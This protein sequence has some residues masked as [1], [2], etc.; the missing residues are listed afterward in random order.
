LH[1]VLS[2]LFLG[3]AALG[4]V[5]LLFPSR[6][7]RRS[8]HQILAIT[9]PS[10]PEPVGSPVGAFESTKSPATPTAA[11]ARENAEPT[12]T[13]REAHDKAATGLPAAT[14]AQT[15]PLTKTTVGSSSGKKSTSLRSKDPYNYR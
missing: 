10:A 15:K 11:A 12:A 2:I 1:V 5:F 14:V 3:L 13:E 4:I 9:Q 6:N 8:E 7:L